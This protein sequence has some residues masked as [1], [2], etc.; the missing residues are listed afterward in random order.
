MPN[1]SKN[2][3]RLLQNAPRVAK[4]LCRSSG[5]SCSHPWVC[6]IS[7]CTG[8]YWNLG[9]SAMNQ[10]GYL[11]NCPYTSNMPKTQWMM[12]LSAVNGPI[13]P[14]PGTGLVFHWWLPASSWKV[15]RGTVPFCCCVFLL[16]EKYGEEKKKKF[17]E[18]LIPCENNRRL[19]PMWMQFTSLYRIK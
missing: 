17:R 8:L 16:E 11:K 5:R 12:T 14:P 1:R 7:M 6:L 18:L 15:K 9:S 10:S 2:C 3:V 19:Y 4:P 13:G